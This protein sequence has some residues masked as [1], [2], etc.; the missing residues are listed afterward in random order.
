MNK[1]A[2]AKLL[3]ALRDRS[4]ECHGEEQEKTAFLGALGLPFRAAEAIAGGL[5]K[6]VGTALGWG[7]KKLL[8]AGGNLFSKGVE[9][10]A[11]NLGTIASLGLGVGF[12]AYFTLQEAEALKGLKHPYSRKASFG[13]AP[14]R[15]DFRARRN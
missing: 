7:G 4:D 1:E 8:G 6:G 13:A 2:R 14:T 12:P 10:T 3:K 15:P 11:A 5:G 9:G